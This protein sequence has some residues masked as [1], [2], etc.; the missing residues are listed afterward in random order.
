[1][2]PPRRSETG[3]ASHMDKAHAIKLAELICEDLNLYTADADENTEKIQR[4]AALL[5]DNTTDEPRTEH[6]RNFCEVAVM[7]RGQIHNNAAYLRLVADSLERGCKSGF[8][9]DANPA[10]GR[11]VSNLP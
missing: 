8:T 4:I 6:G 7:V 2:T 5:R 3:A 11:W 10:D 1:M 9:G